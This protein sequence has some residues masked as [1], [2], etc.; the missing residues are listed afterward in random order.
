MLSCRATPR[1]AHVTGNPARKATALT[2]PLARA[3]SASASMATLGS[4]ATSEV[5][6]VSMSE[7]FVTINCIVTAIVLS[8]CPDSP[9]KDRG[10]GDDVDLEGDADRR[11]KKKNRRKKKCRKQVPLH[12]PNESLSTHRYTHC[13]GRAYVC[14]ILSHLSSLPM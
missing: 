4:T 9:Q 11:K 12:E 13:A 10:G 1:N 5:C 6:V 3:T 8:L 2:W 14:A 7:D